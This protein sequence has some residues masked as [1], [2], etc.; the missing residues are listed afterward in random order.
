[1]MKSKILTAEH[2]KHMINMK[3]T[4]KFPVDK[5][6]GKINI[7]IQAKMKV[8]VKINLKGVE[9]ITWFKT[10]FRWDNYKN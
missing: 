5:T 6:E 10:Q 7:S 4:Y 9:W 8:N 2:M 1:M 3:N